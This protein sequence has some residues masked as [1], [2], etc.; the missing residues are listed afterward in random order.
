MNGID[1][2]AAAGSSPG[3]WNRLCWAEL[4]AAARTRSLARPVQA[5]ARATTEAVAAVVDAV[6]E[7]V[8][9]AFGLHRAL[10][11]HPLRDLHT[12]TVGR[13]ELG[14]GERPAPREVHPGRG[15]VVVGGGQRLVHDWFNVRRI[16]RVP[17]HG[18]NPSPA[19]GAC[20][21]APPGTVHPGGGRGRTQVDK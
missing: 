7:R 13:E 2:S 8:V 1:A 15:E 16:H 12:D 14:G 3:P 18:P 17:R 19:R 21:V 5:V 20:V 4:D 10:G 11:A 9:E 6:R